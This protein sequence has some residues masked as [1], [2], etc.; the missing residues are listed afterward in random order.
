[1]TS[2]DILSGEI[3]FKKYFLIVKEK[4]GQHPRGGVWR[5]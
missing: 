3:L 4:A 2:L 5:F 1:V